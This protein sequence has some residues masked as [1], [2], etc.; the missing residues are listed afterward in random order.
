MLQ[1]PNLFHLFYVCMHKSKRL[2]SEQNLLTGRNFRRKFQ[3]TEQFVFPIKRF[4]GIDENI[5]KYL[6][7]FH[8]VSII[9][10][11]IGYFYFSAQWARYRPII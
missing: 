8:R 11:D 3:F 7:I 4:I 10:A 5:D 2:A 1:R 6:K 9:V